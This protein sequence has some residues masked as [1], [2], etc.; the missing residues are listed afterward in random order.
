MDQKGEVQAIGGA[1]EK[2][3]GFF[4][5]CNARGLTGEQGV[6]IP[7]SNIQHLMLREDVV[8]AVKAGRFHV[9]SIET[10]DE[11]VEILMGV[12]AGQIGADGTYPA[13]SINGRVMARLRRFADEL[14]AFSIH[15][16]H[17]I[18]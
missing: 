8:A 13:D 4:D 7:E 11:A 10:L 1:N 15:H 6:L 18:K 5:V 14:K 16:D 12:P 3:E 2:I 17:P 9:Y